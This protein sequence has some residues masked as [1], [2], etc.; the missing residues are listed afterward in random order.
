MTA[1]ELLPSL[2]SQ[3]LQTGFQPPHP[4]TRRQAGGKGTWGEEA[5]SQEVQ[6]YR[7]PGGQKDPVVRPSAQTLGCHMETEAQGKAMTK[8]SVG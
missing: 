7:K 8:G 4:C 5:A 2:G 1:R 6:R 3:H